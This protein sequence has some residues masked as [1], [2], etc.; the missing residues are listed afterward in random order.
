MVCAALRT[1]A[2]YLWAVHGETTQCSCKDLHP[3]S[4]P[5]II[6][7]DSTARSQLCRWASRSHPPPTCT[8]PHHVVPHHCPSQLAARSSAASTLPSPSASWAPW[9]PRATGAQDP[10]GPATT[11]AVTATAA[12]PI[13]RGSGRGADRADRGGRGSRARPARRRT[14]S[15]SCGRRRCTCCW[16]WWPRGAGRTYLAGAGRRGTHSRRFAGRR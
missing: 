6:T 3:H 14:S 4:R 5:A 2:C 11:T 13:C 10:P 9:H 15:S 12:V 16:G 1:A 8:T 7:T